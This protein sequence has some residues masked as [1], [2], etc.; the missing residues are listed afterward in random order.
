MVQ[1]HTE[2][3]F[4]CPVIVPAR[5]RFHPDV[6]GN[7]G[8][9][10]NPDS[11]DNPDNGGNPGNPDNLDSPDNSDNPLSMVLHHGIHGGLNHN[12]QNRKR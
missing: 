3:N 9:P 10:D 7:P 8:N 11:L 2:S 4:L 1:Y 12:K 6:P 5:W